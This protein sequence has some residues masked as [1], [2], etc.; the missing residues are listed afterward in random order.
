MSSQ[1]SF[2]SRCTA[3]IGSSLAIG[4]IVIVSDV[5][6]AAG[7]AHDTIAAVGQHLV[8][9]CTS[10]ERIRAARILNQKCPR[11]QDT[12]RPVK[13][14]RRRGAFPALKDNTS[15]ESVTS[16]RIIIY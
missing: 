7:V 11:F 9:L 6:I 12:A 10:T 14:H 4:L 15:M 3:V 5:V 8:V 2:L 13:S 1:S 16:G